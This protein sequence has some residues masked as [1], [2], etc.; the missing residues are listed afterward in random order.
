MYQNLRRA[1]ELQSTLK[2]DTFESKYKKEFL[3]EARNN[4]DTAKHIA[5]FTYLEMNSKKKDSVVKHNKM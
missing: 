4:M 2:C 3:K 1:F 5:F